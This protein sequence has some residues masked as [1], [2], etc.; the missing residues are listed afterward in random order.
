DKGEKKSKKRNTLYAT[1]ACRQAGITKRGRRMKFRPEITRVKLNPEQAVLTCACYQPTGYF[2][3]HATGVHMQRP[4]V[5]VHHGICQAD[6]G[7]V[8]ESHMFC[9][10]GTD[11]VGGVETPMLYLDLPMS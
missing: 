11:L 4:E 9:G 2:G 10:F 1:P 8:L 7:R 5:M 3:F 6:G